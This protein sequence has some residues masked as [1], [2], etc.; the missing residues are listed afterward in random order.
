MKEMD[1]LLIKVKRIGTNEEGFLSFM[2]AMRS[3]DFGIKRLYYITGVSEN[4]V[5]GKHA[6]KENNQVLVCLQGKIEV[7]MDNGFKKR[8]FL[9]DSPDKALIVPCGIWHEMKW[10]SDKA[11]LCVIASDYFDESDYIRNYDEFETHIK[12]GYWK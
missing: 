9:L 10:K 8:I 1:N 5:R 2:E 4:S 7:I 11:L 3:F 12:K 6:H